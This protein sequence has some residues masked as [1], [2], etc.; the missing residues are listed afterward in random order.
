MVFMILPKVL[1]AHQAPT[2]IDNFAA[3]KLWRVRVVDLGDSDFEETKL[4]A[5]Q[6]CASVAGAAW[7]FVCSP[8]QLDNAQRLHANYGTKVCWLMHNGKPNSN[9]RR[10]ITRRNTHRI[11]CMSTRNAEQ[12]RAWFGTDIPVYVLRPSYEPAPRWEWAGDTS[13]TIKSR[14]WLRD[15][16]A[17]DHVHQVIRR[18]G[19]FDHRWYG[20]GQPNGFIM[21]GEKSKLM[22]RCSCYVSCLPDWAGFGLTEHECMAAGVPVVGSRWGDT[23]G[24]TMDA[25]LSDDVETQIQCL[26]LSRQ[27][28]MMV[29]EAQYDY[30]RDMCSPER[31]RRSIERFLA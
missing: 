3:C 2:L 19:A 27:R 10:T 12:V 29:S 5:A 1:F 24:R 21:P 26:K 30:L 20:Q 15:R 31:Q 23:A 22:Q 11:A 18:A 28:D 4:L 16:T 17:L 7:V 9:I 13:W 25:L 14:P 6:P 8:M